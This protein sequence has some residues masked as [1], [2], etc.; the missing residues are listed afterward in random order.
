MNVMVPLLSG[1]TV[2]IA[3]FSALCL[4]TLVAKPRTLSL[5]WARLA[6]A[7][8]T[9]ELCEKAATHPID[10]VAFVLTRWP[11]DSHPSDRCEE[12]KTKRVGTYLN[13]GP[14]STKK[15]LGQVFY[16]DF[17]QDFFSN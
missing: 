4:E 7:M 15:N 1:R 12:E 9:S 11:A 8:R 6:L 17:G 16:Q 2:K 3:H 5:R 14:D 13:L 10:N